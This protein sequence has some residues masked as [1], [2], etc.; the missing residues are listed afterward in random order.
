LLYDPE[1]RWG[2]EALC[3]TS[4]PDAFFVNGGLP[5]KAPQPST[6]EAWDAAKAQCQRC[7]VMQQCRRDTLGEEYGVWGGLDEHQRYLVRRALS[8]R[9]RWKTWPEARR[10][11]WGE[12]LAKLR[13]A[14][15]SYRVI[16]TRTGLLPAVVDGLIQE[17]KATLP[18]EAAS[19]IALP[20]PDI[21]PPPFPNTRGS[22]HAWVRN[23]AL[24]A[25]GWYAGE[26]A[27]ARWIRMQIYSGHGNVYKFFRPEDVKF[28]HKQP[29]WVVPYRGRPDAKTVR[30]DAHAA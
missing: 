12:H 28:Y 20:L 9:K 25:D 23:R 11:A 18:S 2:R 22:R 21:E 29:R 26:T 19:V 30:E 8:Q 15:L 27:D 7:P 4:S 3:R 24:I 6:Q 5:D 16:Q 1:R 10:L 14:G 13:T 17:W